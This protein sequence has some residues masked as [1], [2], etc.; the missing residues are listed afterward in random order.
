METEHSPLALVIDDELEDT[1]TVRYPEADLICTLLAFLWRERGANMRVEHGEL[2]LH[3]L[4]AGVWFPDVG[5]G[6]VLRDVR[7]EGLHVVAKLLI[8]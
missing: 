5:L 1:V 4:D 2:K 6:V 7:R 3:V 8:C